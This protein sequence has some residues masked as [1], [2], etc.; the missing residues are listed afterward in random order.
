MKE[1]LGIH[2]RN[3]HFKQPP[4]VTLSQTTAFIRIVEIGWI[5]AEAGLSHGEELH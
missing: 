2:P 1:L 3:V 5:L 4:P